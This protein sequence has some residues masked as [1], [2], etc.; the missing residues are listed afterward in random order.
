[1]A[2]SFIIVIFVSFLSSIPFL[3]PSAFPSIFSSTFLFIFLILIIIIIF[4][5]PFGALLLERVPLLFRFFFPLLFYILI[6]FLTPYCIPCFFP[7]LRIFFFS[8]PLFLHICI[9][10]QSK[11][12]IFRFPMFQISISVIPYIYMGSKFI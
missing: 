10:R 3:F 11:L 1:M 8:N 2:R 12:F 9:T 6:T 7:F 4:P 5:C